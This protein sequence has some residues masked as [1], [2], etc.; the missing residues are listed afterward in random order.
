MAKWLFN[1]I[2]VAVVAMWVFG[3]VASFLKPG[4]TMPA[5]VQLAIGLLCGA[6][7]GK[8]AA[9]KKGDG[10]PPTLPPPNL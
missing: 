4:Y 5:S 6:V 10:A 1:L 9:G 2:S 8:Q 3:C 7:F